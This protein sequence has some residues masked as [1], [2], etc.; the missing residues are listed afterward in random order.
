MV[1]SFGLCSFNVTNDPSVMAE[2]QMTFGRV[3]DKLR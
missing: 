1:G 3:V 2:A